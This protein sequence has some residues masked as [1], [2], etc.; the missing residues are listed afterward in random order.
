MVPLCRRDKRHRVVV[1]QKS[2]KGTC[3]GRFAAASPVESW[4]L[5]APQCLAALGIIRPGSGGRASPRPSLTPFSK[6]AFNPVASF[7]P[8]SD[9]ADGGDSG[10]ALCLFVSAAD[11]GHVICRSDKAAARLQ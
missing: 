1:S 11:L 4:A 8:P 7:H 9:G 6:A 2:T 10:P 3:D 5:T